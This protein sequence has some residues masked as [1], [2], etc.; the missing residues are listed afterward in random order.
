MKKI[1]KRVFWGL[2]WLFLISASGIVM[3]TLISKT[4]WL[5]GDSKNGGKE[6]NEII[7]TQR[8]TEAPDSETSTE[9]DIK[10]DVNLY[11]GDL[12]LP[13]AGATGYAS[14]SVDV[15]RVT[16]ENTNE[17]IA[18]L[19]PGTPFRILIESGAWW[20][21]SAGGVEGWVDHSF[22]MINLPDVIP[23]IIY[24]NTGA[25]SSECIS[26]GEP[27][28]GIS[29]ER[30]YSYSD[31]YDGKA[32][33]E[34][35]QKYEYIVPVLYSTAKRLHIAQQHALANGDTIIMYE[36]FR[37][38]SAQKKT[39]EAVQ[40]F[41]DANPH[42][43]AGIS[44][45]Q[46]NMSWFVAAGVSNHQRGYAV[47]VSLAK[48]ITREYVQ[49]GGYHYMQIVKSEPY[50][51]FSVIGELSVK[52]VVYKNPVQIQSF[53]AWKSAEHSEGMKSSIPAQTLQKYFTDAGFTPLASEWWH[54]N[55]LHTLFSLTKLSGGDFEIKDCLSV[56]PE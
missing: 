52:S 39:V 35:L 9:I 19:K 25:Y 3:M 28:P 37:P 43:K 38:Y 16:A 20:C 10:T 47:D 22:C 6:T 49:T 13:V 8:T 24:D 42:I 48:I 14:V 40:A 5:A 44:T 46:W 51:M 12:E 2:T 34:R 32:Y 29:G 11:A 23:S 41:A 4:G 1:A 18:A 30:L 50:Q 54:F 56:A 31:R 7:K 33:N 26:S 55:D 53:D 15:I 36:A 45:P 27:I 21:I 17:V